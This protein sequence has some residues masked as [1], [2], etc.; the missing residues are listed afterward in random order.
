M[1]SIDNDSLDEEG[2]FLMSGKISAAAGHTADILS[3]ST[4]ESRSI[5]YI[6]QGARNVYNG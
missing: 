2:V 1:V 6:R 5:S 4:L 3:H